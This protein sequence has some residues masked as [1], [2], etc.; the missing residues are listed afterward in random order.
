MRLF[1][2]T[3]FLEN[4]PAGWCVMGHSAVGTE[5]SAPRGSPGWDMQRRDGGGGRSSTSEERLRKKWVE[6]AS[7]CTEEPRPL[8]LW[9]SFV[10]FLTFYFIY[11]FFLPFFLIDYGIT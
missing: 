4:W 5:R 11:L 10:F 8:I 2:S 3:C 6:A 9:E 7:S 1:G